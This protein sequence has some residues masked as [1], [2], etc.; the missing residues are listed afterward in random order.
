[1]IIFEIIILLIVAYLLGS[2]TTSVWVGKFFFGLDIREYGS[3]NAGAS[4]TFR[5]LGLKAGIAVLVID[6]LKGFLAVKLHLLTSI[7]E[8]YPQYSHIFM[9]CLSIF[10][11]IGHIFPIYAGFRGG[12]GV[13][14]LFGSVIAIHPQAAIVSAFVFIF[15]FLLFRY[16]SLSSMTA[17]ISYPIVLILI[18][19][20]RSL[21]LI[22]FSVLI[23]ALLLLTH[24][25]NIFRLLNNQ[26]PKAR[27]RP[28]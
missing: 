13:A 5:T 17:G 16:F 27:F 11:V 28:K 23:A 10:A 8:H 1:M 20:V 9:I 26:E 3:G 6:I 7:P 12:K 14:T 25:K 24:R 19:D 22:I 21:S 4:N 2:V 15:M 18:F